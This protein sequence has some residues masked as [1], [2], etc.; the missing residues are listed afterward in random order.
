MHHSVAFV[1][2]DDGAELGLVV[3][4]MFAILILAG[5]YLITQLFATAFRK[6]PVVGP[7]IA[8]AF[9]FVTRWARGAMMATFHGLLWACGKIAHAVMAVLRNM[10][11]LQLSIVSDIVDAAEHT[12]FT[13]IPREITAARNFALNQ[14][15]QAYYQ[16]RAYTNQEISKENSAIAAIRTWASG[17]LLDLQNTLVS[18]INATRKVLDARITDAVNGLTAQIQALGKKEQ[19]DIAKAEA[20]IATAEKLAVQQA[21]TTIEHWANQG[22]SAAWAGEW[23]AIT[24]GVDL[25]VKTAGTDFQEIV[26]PLKVLVTAEPATM[27]EAQAAAAAF[28]PPV[29]RFLEECGLPACRDLGNLRNLLHT[30]QDALFAAL[31]LAWVLQAILDPKG[32]ARETYDAFGPLTTGG[33]D[34]IKTLGGVP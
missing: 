8:S 26:Q 9:D 5:L 1:G 25:V 10:Y 32:W 20:D 16:A 21:T 28:I 23:A 18:L 34:L 6:I 19:Q 15:N 11:E 27:A 4:A 2:V 22:A 29:L 3:V 17:K 13:V 7:P 12:R 31:L 33:I 24:A 14:A 30:L